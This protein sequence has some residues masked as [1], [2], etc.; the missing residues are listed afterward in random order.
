MMHREGHERGTR[1]L[2]R[3]KLERPLL[4]VGLVVDRPFRAYG[5]RD[6]L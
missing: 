2:E 3:L 1:G 4:A 6:I 5:P